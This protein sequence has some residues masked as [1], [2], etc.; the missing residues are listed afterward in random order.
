MNQRDYLIKQIQADYSKLDGFLAGLLADLWLEN[1]S[2]EIFD[3]NEAR[4]ARVIPGAHDK[5]IHSICQMK[6]GINSFS[7]FWNL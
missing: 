7:M 5:Q 2:V 6:V 3:M 1:K 4:S